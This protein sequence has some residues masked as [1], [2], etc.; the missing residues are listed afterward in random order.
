MK[1]FIKFAV[2]SA[3]FFSINLFADFLGPGDKITTVSQVKYDGPDTTI[4]LQG[5]IIKKIGQ[6]DYLFKDST[7]EI[8][9]EINDPKW[10]NMNVTTGTLIRI[11][12][13]PGNGRI[14]NVDLEIYKVVIVKTG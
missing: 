2:L 11:Y 12:G 6:W 13:K 14:G 8:K 1:V 3:L 5:N 10:V 9:I 7:G 4:I